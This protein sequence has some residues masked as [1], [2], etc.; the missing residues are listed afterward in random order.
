M[1]KTFQSSLFLAF[2][3]N[4]FPFGMFQKAR[5]ILTQILQCE[6]AVIRSATMVGHASGRDSVLL[7]NNEKESPVQNNMTRM[8]MAL[9]AR[10]EPK[11]N[12]KAGRV[13]TMCKIVKLLCEH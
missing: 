7:L 5:V 6:H 3:T 10:Q 13:H 2:R 11:R 1:P 8:L 4:C 9:P 12:T